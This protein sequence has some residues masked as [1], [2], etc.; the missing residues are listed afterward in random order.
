MI[1]QDQKSE[2]GDFFAEMYSQQAKLGS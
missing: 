2:G 1:S